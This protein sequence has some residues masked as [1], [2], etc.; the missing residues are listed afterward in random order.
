[1][2]L[3]TQLEKGSMR[4]SFSA[5]GPARSSRWIW[6]VLH[7]ASNSLDVC[8]I[9]WLV[10]SFIWKAKLFVKSGNNRHFE[11]Q[12]KFVRVGICDPRGKEIS[13]DEA[14]VFNLI[15]MVMC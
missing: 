4:R 6:L 5:P 7:Q 9:I 8:G 13:W 1:M 2:F 10:I 15:Y 3:P 12:I 11:D 14:A